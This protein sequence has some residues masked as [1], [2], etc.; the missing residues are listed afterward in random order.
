VLRE[1]CG[2]SELL[3][4]AEARIFNLGQQH[5]RRDFVDLSSVLF[6]TMKTYESFHGL[7]SGITGIATGYHNLDQML[8]GM[9]KSELIILAARPRWAKPPWRSTSR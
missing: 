8:S 1:R 6:T 2:S 7:K 3:D 4:Q 9:Q 5:E